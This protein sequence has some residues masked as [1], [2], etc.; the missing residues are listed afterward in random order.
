MRAGCYRVTITPPIGTYLAGYDARTEPA[1][2]V[3]DELDAR[4]FVLEDPSGA[5]VILAADVLQLPAAYVDAVRASIVQTTGIPRERILLCAT[6]THSAPD[7]E[8]EYTPGGP[9]RCLIEMW[10]RSL[11]GCAEAAWRGRGDADVGF[12][13]GTVD[14]IGVN[15]RHPDG[16]PVD[17]MVGVVSARAC[18]GAWACVLVNYTCH[19]V[20]LG[21]D[22]LC[23]SA[24][25]PGYARRAI[26]AVEG[27]RTLAIFTNGAEGDVNTGHSADLAEIGVPIPGRTFARARDLGHRLAGEVI[28]V[29]GGPMTR[30]GG[31]IAATAREVLL[32]FREIQP[33]AAAEAALS[34]ADQEVDRL[35]ASGAATAVV[36]A[37]K[38][39]RFHAAVHQDV[40]RRRAATTAPGV[41]AEL[42]VLRVGDLALV[43]IPGELFV[44]LGLAVKARSP[45]PRT[46]VLGLANGSVGYLPT[47]EACESG[48]YEAVATPFAIGTGEMVRDACLEMLQS[49]KEGHA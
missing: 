39:R 38:I 24:D 25:Y 22:N 13:F 4:C 9:D 40:A 28:K 11:A 35:V 14:G 15:R 21:A 27:P 36:T 29:L 44:E 8:G 23:I 41:T 7:L 16:Q 20:V 17:P 26:E 45:F 3:H 1:R 5:V 46:L 19:P 34:A 37:A 2:G 48:G 47:R 42:Q 12:G 31:P 10:R 49:L 18:G 30:L 32:P 43:G 33:P 6:H